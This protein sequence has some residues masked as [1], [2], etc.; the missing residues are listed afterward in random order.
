MKNKKEIEEYTTISMSELQE[1]YKLREDY[2]S[3]LQSEKKKWK[4]EMLNDLD[5]LKVIEPPDVVEEL[6]D[7]RQAFIAGQMNLLMR[8]QQLREKIEKL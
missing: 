7:K 8:I 2:Q 4:A 5:G 1:L 3:L 6:S